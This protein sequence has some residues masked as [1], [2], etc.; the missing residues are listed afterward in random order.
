M[1]EISNEERVASLEMLLQDVSTERGW[2]NARKVVF[3]ALRKE[4][5]SIF[6]G[7]DEQDEQNIS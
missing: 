7:Q 2:A 4:E 3:D 5:K 6:F 1:G